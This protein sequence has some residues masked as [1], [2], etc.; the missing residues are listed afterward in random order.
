VGLSITPKIIYICTD[1][2]L[3]DAPSRGERA[4]HMLERD[5]LAHTFQL[6]VEL[7][8]TFIDELLTTV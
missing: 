8:I 4:P 5:R 2:N 7:G 3:A 6:P 1:N